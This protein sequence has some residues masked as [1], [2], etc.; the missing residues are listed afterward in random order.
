MSRTLEVDWQQ[1][2]TTILVVNE[3]G[4]FTFS[5][6]STPGPELL[7]VIDPEGG[8]DIDRDAVLDFIAWEVA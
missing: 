3:D 6:S 7:R 8:Q 2:H 1:E 4:S 5:N